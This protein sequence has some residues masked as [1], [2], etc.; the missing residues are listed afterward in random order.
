[1]TAHT[2]EFKTIGKYNCG[3]DQWVDREYSE[4][5][6][7]VGDTEDFGTYT[8]PVD[9]EDEC[10]GHEHDPSN[11]TSVAG[12]STTCDGS[13]NREGRAAIHYGT[14]WLL[15][16]H[17]QQGFVNVATFGREEDRDAELQRI[18]ELWGAFVDA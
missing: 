16:Q 9:L 15:V 5:A 6:D 4:F 7:G 2:D 11:P 12:V 17:D 3:T 14:R 10:Q 13:C 18:S 8:Y 1:M